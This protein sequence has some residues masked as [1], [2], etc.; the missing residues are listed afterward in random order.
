[1]KNSKN[2]TSKIITIEGSKSISNRLLVINYIRKLKNKKPLK[3][4]NLGTCDDIKLMQ[5]GLKKLS[6]KNPGTINLGYSGTAVRFLTSLASCLNKKVTITGEKRM[7]VRPIKDLADALKSL[8]ANIKTAKNGC[9]PIKIEPSKTREIDNKTKLNKIIE[10]KGDKS[11]QFISSLLLV[12]PLLPKGL[13]IRVQPKTKVSTP[14]IEMTKKL[15]KVCEGKA[16]QNKP[17]VV[18]SDA[19]SASYIGAYA[20]LTG[21][22]VEINHLPKNSIQG[23]IKF[24]DYLKKMGCKTTHK[25]DAVAVIGPK[26][27]KSLGTLDMNKTPDLVMTFAILATQTKG[28]TRITNI[29]NLRIKESD[30]LKA[31][32]NEIKK[33]GIKVN[34]T[35]DSITIYGSNKTTSKKIAIET[36]ND[37]RIAMAFGILKATK[38][39][40]IVIKHPEVV[41]KSYP[42]FWK[43]LKSLTTKNK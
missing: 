7:L 32:K 13:K 17:I 35:K 23:D 27:L 37:H 43:D 18:E 5:M 22:K 15:I 3:I 26:T 12:S 29:G 39:P 24:V 19:S 2:S 6:Q 8:G 31:L 34:T 33:L 36:Y 11:S 25:K 14:Y 4:I 28:K 41:K 40:N 10:I 1:M 21:Q 38:F 9:P 20:A 16:S 42:N 30:R